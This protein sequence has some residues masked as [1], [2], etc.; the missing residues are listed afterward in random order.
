VLPHQRDRAGG[1]RH[2][3]AAAE[4]AEDGTL[5]VRGE[6]LGAY[7]PTLLVLLDAAAARAPQSAFLVERD[8]RDV[9]HRATFDTVAR[10]SYNVAGGLR[11]LGASE[12]RPVMILSENGID[13]ALVTF[14]ALRAGIP[15]VP[16]SAKTGLAAHDGF[17]RLRAIADAVRPGVVF[18]RDGAA[19]AA[20]AR[21][22]APDAAFVSV[23]EPPPGTPR[24]FDYARLLA[25]APF[26]PDAAGQIDEDTV[27][28]I[29]FVSGS[30]GETRGVVVTHGMIGAMLQCVAQAWPFLDDHPPVL[31]DWL[32]WSHGL[33]GNLVLGIALRH[34][35]TLYVDDGDPTPER[36]ERTVR[37]RAE[38][39]P[40][41]A[42]DVPLG[43]TAWVDRLRGDDVLRRHWLSRLDR[44]CWAGA[45]LA[46]ATRDA[47]RAIG[48]PL[49]AAWGSTEASPVIALTPGADP[50]ADALGV[51]LAGVELKLV[52]NGDAYEARVRGAQVMHG[53]FWRPDLT[54]QAFDDKGFYRMGDLV[55]PVDARAPERGLAFVSRLDERF[56][57]ASG[58]WVLAGELRSAFLAECSDAADVLVSGAGHDAVGL[59]VWPSAEGRLLDRDVLRAQVADAMRRLAAGAGPAVRPRRAL[60]VDTN[61]GSDERART[62]ALK[63]VHASEPD[64]EVI[65]L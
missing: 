41:L 18:A 20:A 2:L 24:A 39:A 29:L 40:T 4:R 47:L 61:D 59:L 25:H 6:P 14:G 65:V 28:K 36:F 32:P 23:T 7:P 22:V 12:T 38:I 11:A 46:P 21:A 48:V 34:A 53:Y 16:V 3:T 35:G 42:F 10:R 52:P 5:R 19:Y 49:A 26:A 43:W 56:K 30:T 58:V 17:A 33:G 45:T 63:R 8:A 62:A 51:P 64:A 57:L 9:W 27:A 31:V 44:A 1:R 60:I 55:R 54:A 15:V 50:A 37:L 13:H